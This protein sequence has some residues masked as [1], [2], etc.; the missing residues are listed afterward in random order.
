MSAFGS[1]LSYPTG[2]FPTQFTQS[3]P[4]PTTS[5]SYIHPQTGQ[6]YH[7]ATQQQYPSTLQ[8]AP[9]PPH[10]IYDNEVSRRANVY[11]AG[12]GY[13]P[14]TY[15]DPRHLVSYANN[16]PLFQGGKYKKSRKHKKPKKHKKSRKHRKSKKH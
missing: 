15:P 10:W 8:H 6:P 7:T 3:A 5:S 16:D 2:Q 1:A 14:L 11:G 4:S 13:A 12:L 9:A